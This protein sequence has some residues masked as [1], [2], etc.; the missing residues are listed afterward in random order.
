MC[1]SFFVFCS[2]VLQCFFVLFV[3][4]LL[5][6]FD[7]LFFPLFLFFRVFPFFSL[8][9]FFFSPKRYQKQ[10]CNGTPNVP[11]TDPNKT[12]KT[13]CSPRTRMLTRML[14]VQMS[15]HMDMQSRTTLFCNSWFE[16]SCTYFP[17]CQSAVWSGKFRV[18]SVE[19]KVRS[20][21]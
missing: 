6:C 9:C 11:Q 7:S 15:K 21:K 4:L 14:M 5:C 17:C 8:L 3:S 1:L 20:V 13:R 2:S 19:C 12:K 18:W 16:E 10:K